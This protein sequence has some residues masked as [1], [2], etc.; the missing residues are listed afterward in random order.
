MSVR[1][2]ACSRPLLHTVWISWSWCG[3]RFLVVPIQRF[4]CS[5]VFLELIEVVSLTH[6]SL[7]IDVGY[8]V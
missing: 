6:D 5:R 1:Y 7:Q 2:F 4:T 8:A 3:L